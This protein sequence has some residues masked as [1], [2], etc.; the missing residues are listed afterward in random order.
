MEIKDV[1]SRNSTTELAIQEIVSNPSIDV[2]RGLEELVD[3]LHAPIASHKKQVAP[4][5]QV[6]MKPTAHPG[7][8]SFKYS[9]TAWVSLEGSLL[10]RVH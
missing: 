8:E 7:N 3:T 1:F 10:T 2:Q 5:K 6:E 4:E 9:P